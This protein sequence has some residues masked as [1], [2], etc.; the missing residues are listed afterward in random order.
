MI[1]LSKKAKDTIDVEV[2]TLPD[3]FR[4]SF[5]SVE[6]KLVGGVLSPSD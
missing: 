5:R 3:G 4:A 1:V 6:V 2:V